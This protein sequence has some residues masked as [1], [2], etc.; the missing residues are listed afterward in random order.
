MANNETPGPIGTILRI[1]RM[2]T[3]DGP[4]IR[5]TV[6]FKGCPL[7]C[8]WCHNP[9]SISRMQEPHWMRA[10]CIGCR[11]CAAACDRGAIQA[12]DR[13]IV[14][15]RALCSPCEAC[16]QACPTTA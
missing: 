16:S 2:S 8:L 12:A 11:S 1:Q 14:I 6:F 5:S 4:G 13:G 7:N 3:E 10:K 9:E 15:D